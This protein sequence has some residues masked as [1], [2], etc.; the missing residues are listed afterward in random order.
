MVSFSNNDRFDND[1]IFLR[2]IWHFVTFSII[3]GIN[4]VSILFVFILK[5]HV[6]VI[7]R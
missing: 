2:N 1:N 3:A 6:I 7:A 5:I 4:Y